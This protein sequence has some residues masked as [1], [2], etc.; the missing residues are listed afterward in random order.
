MGCPDGGTGAQEEA[1]G[2]PLMRH[3]F[4]EV[5]VQ[6]AV[7]SKILKT[8]KPADVAWMMRSWADD[9]ARKRF[10]AEV[11][12]MPRPLVSV[13]W[14]LEFGPALRKEARELSGPLTALLGGST[15]PSVRAAASG[16][17]GCFGA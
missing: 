7:V 10:F 15:G 17:C 8:A 3:S 1:D 12:G 2:L 9:A 4:T 14:A 13:L 5:E 6:K 11:A 16:G